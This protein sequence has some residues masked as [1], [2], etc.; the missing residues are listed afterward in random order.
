VNVTFFPWEQVADDG[1]NGP[2][3]GSGWPLSIQTLRD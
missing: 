2:T 3:T 1:R